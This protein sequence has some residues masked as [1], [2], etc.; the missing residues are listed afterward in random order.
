MQGTQ[1]QTLNDVVYEYSK[2]KTSFNLRKNWVE[3]SEKQLWEE[4]CIC[5]LSSNVPYDLALSAFCHLGENQFLNVDKIIANPDITQEISFEL[6]R[7]IYEPKR[8]D[9]T[10]RKYR[11]PNARASD[12][13]KAAITLYCENNG[14]SEL[15]KN[16]RSEKQARRFLAENVSGIGLK[17]ASHFLRNVGYSESLAIVDT[18]VVSFLIA[19][20]ELSER[21]TT[22]TPAVYMKLENVLINL[23]D[24]LGLNM[25]IFDMAIWN[26]M[27]GKSH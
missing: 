11:F 25:S 17:E 18:H 16:S 24:S 5:I 1:Q 3:L 7:R 4:L 12:I 26:Y 15:L 14:L 9:G 13:A 2:L 8:R 27:K 19:I 20:G 10:F 21:V 6:S 23:C 22:V